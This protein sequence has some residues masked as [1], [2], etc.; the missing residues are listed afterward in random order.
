MQSL[1]SNLQ[2]Q[3]PYTSLGMPYNYSMPAAMYGSSL[4]GPAVYQSF[5]PTPHTMSSDKGK[6]KALDADFEAAFAQATASL[7]I[8]DTNSSAS[9]VELEPDSTT[10]EPV[11]ED[12][13]TISEL[14][15]IFMH[16]CLETELTPHQ[17]MAAST[18][19]RCTTE[20]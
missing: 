7:R 4:T 3:H 5:N 1:T 20:G 18:R 13:K 2:V 16:T 15:Y 11:N 6:G 17:G 12:A 9:I 10:V 8:S 14:V 19:I